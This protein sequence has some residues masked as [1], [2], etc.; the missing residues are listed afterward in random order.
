MRIVFDSNIYLAAIKEKTF[1]EQIVFSSF[2]DRDYTVF[3]SIDILAEV[4]NK[5]LN[6]FKYTRMQ[7]SNYLARIRSVTEL[8]FPEM[9]ITGVLTDTDDHKI[10]ECALQAKAD[11]LVT[12]DKGLLRLKEYKGIAICHP[13][14]MKYSL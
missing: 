11:C 1:S 8:V 5:L 4:E 7:A 12:A 6:K 9:I 13:S 14:M 10:L 3:V 2:D